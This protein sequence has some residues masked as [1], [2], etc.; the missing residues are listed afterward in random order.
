MKEVTLWYRQDPS[1]KAYQ[2]N[3]F[4]F[5]HLSDGHSTLSAPEPINDVQRATWKNALWRTEH[6]YLDANYKVVDI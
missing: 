3:P 4:E 1:P 6:K 2:P 5:N